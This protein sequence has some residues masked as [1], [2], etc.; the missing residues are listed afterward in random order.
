MIEE[1]KKKRIK[2]YS[3]GNYKDAKGK[4]YCGDN[5]KA[6]AIH[7]ETGEPVILVVHDPRREFRHDHFKKL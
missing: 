4:L 2:S 7:L 5:W 1:T 6:E 3:N